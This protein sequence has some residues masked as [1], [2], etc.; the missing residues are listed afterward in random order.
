M[1]VPPLHYWGLVVINCR[2]PQPAKCPLCKMCPVLPRLGHSTAYSAFCSILSIGSHW[3]APLGGGKT[4]RGT[5]S[6]PWGGDYSTQQKSFIKIEQVLV[7]SWSWGSHWSSNLLQSDSQ[8]YPELLSPLQPQWSHEQPG[9]FS[10]TEPHG[11]GRGVLAEIMHTPWNHGMVWVERTLK[12][13]QSPATGRDTFSFSFSLFLFIFLF[14]DSQ[15]GLGWKGIYVSHRIHKKR[16]PRVS[17]AAFEWIPCPEG[18]E[19]PFRAA[20]SAGEAPRA[21]QGMFR[22]QQCSLMSPVLPQLS[23]VGAQCWCKQQEALLPLYCWTRFYTPTWPV[24]TNVH[25]DIGN[26]LD[27]RML[28]DLQTTQSHLQEIIQGIRAPVFRLSLCACK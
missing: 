21:L 3:G 27:F 15:S 1:E 7:K 28:Y 16:L 26:A 19:P 18:V 24:L 22:L 23:A 2:F 10:G 4:G 17:S 9:T 12:L 25:V 20:R 6:A 13:I 8:N 5:S 14:I 11:L